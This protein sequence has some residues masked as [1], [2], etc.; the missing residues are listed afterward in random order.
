MKVR[1]ESRMAGSH[2][3]LSFIQFCSVAGGQVIE[4]RCCSVAV[5]MTLVIIRCIHN[6]SGSTWYRAH[7]VTDEMAAI[8]ILHLGVL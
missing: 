1:V 5:V 4:K 3:F 6:A 2:N 8:I 7:K